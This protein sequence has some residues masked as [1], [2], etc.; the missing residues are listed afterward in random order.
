MIC[1]SRE[2]PG[3][4]TCVTPC[5]IELT[6]GRIQVALGTRFTA[7]TRFMDVDIAGLLDK[8]YEETRSRA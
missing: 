7:G 1:F 2:A 4:W 3:Q 5:Q 6:G 8:E